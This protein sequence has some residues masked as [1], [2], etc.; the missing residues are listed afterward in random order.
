MADGPRLII[1]VAS[2]SVVD[3]NLRKRG[4][5]QR[6]DVIVQAEPADEHGHLE[7]P[8]AGEVVLT[9]PSP[10]TLSHQPE[11]VRR[12]LRRTNDLAAPPVIIVEA[13]EDLFDDDLAALLDGAAHAAAPVIV[14]IMRDA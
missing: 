5:D 1:Q 14:R 13:A 4:L 7:P 3:Q 12:V 6:G 8:E 2:G 11:E 10:E 9:V